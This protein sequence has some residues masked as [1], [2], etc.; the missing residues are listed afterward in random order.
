MPADA[1]TFPI[2]LTVTDAAGMT[3]QVTV[4]LTVA[5]KLQIATFAVGRSRVGKRYR[6]ALASRGGVGDTKWSVAAGA[7]PP[8]LTLNTVTGVISGTARHAGRYRFT[9]VATDSLQAKAAMTYTLTVKH[10]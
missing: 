5:P 7:L 10:S 4:T 9:V 6:L 3:A 8:G 2:V 1:G